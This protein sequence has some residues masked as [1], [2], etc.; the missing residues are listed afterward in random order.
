M[1]HE[2]KF[3]ASNK[4][5]TRERKAVC[6]K[7]VCLAHISATSSLLIETPNYRKCHA[8]DYDDDVGKLFYSSLLSKNK[9]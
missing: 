4:N 2:K 9:S 3:H 1:Q 8:K 6:M 7:V 5:I